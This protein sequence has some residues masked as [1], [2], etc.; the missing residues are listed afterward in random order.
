MP[1]LSL[2]SRSLLQL[3]RNAV[4]VYLATGQHLVF[5]TDLPELTAKRGCFVTL[6][7]TGKLRGCVGTFDAHRPLYQNIIRM[8]PAAA[9]QDLRFPPVTKEELPFIR[10]ELSV[11]GELEKA[12]SLE[13]I[14][15]GRHGVYVKLDN[16]SGTFLPEVAVEQKWS[17]P[18]FVTYCARDKAGLSP[19]ECTRAEIFRYEVQKFKE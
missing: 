2:N 15:I 13:G 17:V 16:R 9:C 14:E 18:E 6:R 5:Q 1:D 7:K 3:A 19:E 10:I 12:D 11:L 8:A 4:E